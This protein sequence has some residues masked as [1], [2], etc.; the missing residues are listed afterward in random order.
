MY[1]SRLT[2]IYPYLVEGGGGQSMLT[3]TLD[4]PNNTNQIEFDNFESLKSYG[5]R[6]GGGGG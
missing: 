2:N 4:Y 1:S 3:S 6:A 5:V